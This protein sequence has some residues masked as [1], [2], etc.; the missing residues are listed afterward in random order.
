MPT[1][2]LSNSAF[3]RKLESILPLVSKPSRY[4]GNE[5]HVVQKHAA[6]KAAGSQGRAAVMA[7]LLLMIATLSLLAYRLTMRRAVRWLS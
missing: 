4:L 2:P 5:F 7:T 6:Q 1:K 3:T